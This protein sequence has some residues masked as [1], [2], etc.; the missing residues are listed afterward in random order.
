MT[1]T[2]PIRESQQRYPD[3]FS[4]RVA[5]LSDEHLSE[6]NYVVTV[7][8]HDEKDRVG[9]EALDVLDALRDVIVEES[10]HRSATLWN[11]T[12]DL[13]GGHYPIVARDATEFGR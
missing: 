7:G 11:T 6:V 5:G 1:E 10:N 3:E 8:R 2:R 9:S 13:N 12:A 4:G